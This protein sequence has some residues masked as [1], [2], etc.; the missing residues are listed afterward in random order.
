[1]VSAGSL[2]GDE[3][4]QRQAGGAGG[5]PAGGGSP[6]QQLVATIE[7]GEGESGGVFSSVKPYETI[8]ATAKH[9]GKGIDVFAE[10]GDKHPDDRIE[11]RD[12]QTGDLVFAQTK[13][14]GKWLK[15]MLPIR[16][17]GSEGWV[18]RGAVDLSVTD[19]SAKIDLS[20]HVISVRQKDKTF[21]EFS[22]GLGQPD[23][24]TPTGNFYVTELIQPKEPDTIYGAY[25]FVLSGFSNKL[26]DY[27]GGNG[28]I[29]VH[30]TNDPSGIGQDVSAGCIR[31][32]NSAVTELTKRLPLGTPIEIV[33]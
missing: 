30:G 31:M 19:W 16:P 17:N 26:T 25:V 28:E 33:K 15:V 13:R 23:T 27:A 9:P 1:M 20:D 5:A 14:R 29:G 11:L 3:V 10:P 6:A 2:F 8:I 12:G 21:Q 7:G 22:I 18:W 24:P 4:P 32:R